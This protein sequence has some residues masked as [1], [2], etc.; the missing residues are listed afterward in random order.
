LDEKEEWAEENLREEE[1]TGTERTR[2][3]GKVR[4]PPPRQNMEADVNIPSCTFTDCYEC[5]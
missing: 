1:G 5:S 3:E 2:E 4:K